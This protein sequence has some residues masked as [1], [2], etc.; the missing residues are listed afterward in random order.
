MLR[1]CLLLALG[2]R[3]EVYDGQ[4]VLGGGERVSTIDFV[5]EAFGIK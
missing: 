4:D 5:K 2:I 1:L 3:C